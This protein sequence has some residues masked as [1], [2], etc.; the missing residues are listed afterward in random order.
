M[1]RIEASTK[2]IG[3]LI[4][5]VSRDIFVAE[6]AGNLTGGTHTTYTVNATPG[7]EPGPRTT[8][9]YQNQEFSETFIR[10]S[11]IVP[12]AASLHL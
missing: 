3:E 8:A 10:Q 4:M 5:E 12:I 6:A 9:S 11:I 7:R 2:L 1:E